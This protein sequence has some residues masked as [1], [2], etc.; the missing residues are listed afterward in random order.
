MSQ[1]NRAEGWQYAKLSGHQRELDLAAELSSD[2]EL[3]SWLH[4]QSF[5]TP[6]AAQP[7]VETSGISMEW[8][9]S[10]LG[11]LTVP[12]YDLEVA[13]PHRAVKVSLKKSEAGQVWLVPLDRFIRGFQAQFHVGVPD[14]VREGL[15]LFIG[16]LELD[17]MA[18]ILDGHEPLG[19]QARSGGGPQE[20]HQRR[21][22]ARTLEQRRPE[23]WAAALQWFRDEAPRITELCFARGL[24]KDPALYAEAILYTLIS[25]E[26][27]RNYYFSLDELIEV[28]HA[29][30]A[31]GRAR[32]GPLRG[33]STIL[34]PFGFLQ[35]H[36]PK[37]RGEDSHRNQLQFH[38]RLQDLVALFSRS[39]S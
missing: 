17:E 20:L 1:R 8:V 36:N 28:V 30:P 13:W 12:K 24:V 23:L 21:F 18:E 19:G 11:D 14:E 39:S 37:K 26:A 25:G 15:R 2:S 5:G 16:P 35:M 31:A 33:G 4:I 3:S 9:P 38:H 27:A 22:V 7:R 34:L 29:E 6:E 32:P 10:V